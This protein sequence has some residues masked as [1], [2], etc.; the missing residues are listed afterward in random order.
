MKIY[1]LIKNR[2]RIKSKAIKELSRLIV[3]NIQLGG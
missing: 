2:N 3:V 1:A